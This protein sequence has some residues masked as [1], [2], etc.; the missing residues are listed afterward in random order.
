[1]ATAHLPP[2]K[3]EQ[4]HP[5]GLHER[6]V[7]LAPIAW[8]S[9]TQRPH[10]MVACF[11]RQTGGQV[12]WVDPYPTRLPNLDD[13]L[14]PSQAALPHVPVPPWLKVIKPLALPIEPLPLSAW[15]NR[16]LWRGTVRAVQAFARQ[17]ALL[18]VGKP[19][20]LALQ[21]MA[22]PLLSDNCY[23]AMDDVSLFYKGWSRWAMARREQQTVLA[24]RRVWCSSSAL[25][26]RVQQLGATPQ[27][28]ANAC[29]AERLLAPSRSARAAGTAP[30]IGYVGAIAKWFDWSL[31]IA[32]AQ[33]RPDACVRLIGPVFGQVPAHLP[34]N[35]HLRPQCSHTDAMRAMRDFD[36]GLIPFKIDTLTESV[37]PIKYYEYRALGIPVISS[38][39]GEMRQHAKADGV[40]LA[41]PGQPLG[42]TLARALGYREPLASV[43]RFRAANAWSTRFAQARLF[44]RAP[45]TAD[46]CAP[47]PASLDTV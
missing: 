23:D 10:E 46:A 4:P 38:A 26:Q 2:L 43:Q 17:P 34:A 19:S 5:A 32:L 13:V 37:D 8:Q 7:Y 1:M 36:V 42:P 27:W 6:M 41:D 24:A 20:H 11:H 15:L 39:F 30:L 9:V 25:M 18:V 40:F 45:A 31:V 14:G 3:P 28:V 47:R 12:L 29:A 21:L 22:C 33:A 16:W 44:V 35:I